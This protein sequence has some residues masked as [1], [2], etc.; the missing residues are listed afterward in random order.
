MNSRFLVQTFFVGALLSSGHALAESSPW[1]ETPG[2]K[3]RLLVDVPQE[4]ARTLRGAIQID[5]AEGW[6]TYWR[7]PGDAGVPPQLDLAASSNVAKS[8]IAFP[9]PQRFGD[10][11]AQ[12]AGYKHSVVLPVTFDLEKPSAPTHLKGQVFLGICETICIPV[13]A[14]FDLAVKPGKKDPL[15]HTLVSA[16]FDRLPQPSS[17]EFGIHEASRQGGQAVFSVRLPA[18][19]QPAELFL[20]GGAMTFSTPK[21]EAAG[22]NDARFFSDILRG[23]E[24]TPAVVDYTLV[25]GGQAVS[26][27]VELR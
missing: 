5:L 23:A 8:E 13:Q 24:K 15:A 1:V 7:E 27:T 12:W 2:G 9:A 25:Q 17:P 21:F 20:S 4:P 26:G 16:A 14:A 22:A 19:G 18:G 6:K 11:E 10:G 3:V